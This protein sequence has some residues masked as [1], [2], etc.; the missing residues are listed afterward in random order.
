[1]G[2]PAATDLSGGASARVLLRTAALVKSNTAR[3]AEAFASIIDVLRR[4]P[5]Y[6][7]MIVLTD[8]PSE[9]P[10]VT[11]YRDAV[12]RV[13]GI[14]SVGLALSAGLRRAIGAAQP[15]SGRRPNACARAPSASTPPT[16]ASRPP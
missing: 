3:Q 1:M 14:E 10:T 8:G 2:K 4:V 13:E 5:G 12:S 9:A 6:K 16:L 7:Q 11:I 15:R